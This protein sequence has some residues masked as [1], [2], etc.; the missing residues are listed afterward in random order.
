[1]FFSL[2]KIYTK[3]TTTLQFLNCWKWFADEVIRLF[4]LLSIHPCAFWGYSGIRRWPGEGTNQGLLFLSCFK[5][6][7]FNPQMT[8][9]L[10]NEVELYKKK[11][12]FLRV[13]YMERSEK[14]KR[15]KWKWRSIDHLLYYSNVRFAG[16]CST[17]KGDA[18]KRE[19][20]EA[21]LLLW[22][23]PASSCM[24]FT[25]G[26]SAKASLL[27]FQ[28]SRQLG[29]VMDL[30]TTSLSLVGLQPPSDRQ[31]DGIDLLP[32]ILQGKLIDRLVMSPELRSLPPNWSGAK[33][34]LIIFFF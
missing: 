29:S 8:Q 1:M 22:D 12:T 16:G 11:N 4:L 27:M 25:E 5:C 30:F 23:K 2:I 28:V 21:V 31:I 26:L 19:A 15:G 13:G 32:A 9:N 18:L 14:E 7:F 10:L 3:N 33:L 6:W 34:C 20:Q 24:A 17:V